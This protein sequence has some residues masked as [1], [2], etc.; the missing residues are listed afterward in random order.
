[1]WTSDLLY[2]LARVTKGAIYRSGAVTPNEFGGFEVGVYFRQPRRAAPSSHTLKG[3]MT[4]EQRGFIEERESGQVDR[5][6]GAVPYPWVPEGDIFS[7]KGKLQSKGWRSFGTHLWRSKI[8]TKE[9]L[10]KALGAGV[11]E[12]TY[13]Q[14]SFEN[15]RRWLEES[16]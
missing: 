12:S 1:M 3:E 13:D 10:A 14:L 2:K 16:K 4:R 8:L 15:K 7:P 11:G 6:L 9:Q 5:Y